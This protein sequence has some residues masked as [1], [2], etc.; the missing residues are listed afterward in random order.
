MN[1]KS[2]TKDIKTDEELA[3]ALVNFKAVNGEM[4]HNPPSYD[5]LKSAKLRLLEL[6]KRVN[7]LEDKINK[8]E[9]EKDVAHY[10]EFKAN[11]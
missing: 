6:S 9:E 1:D 3:K 4:I 7:Q 11:L 10:N 5:V 2:D 8:L